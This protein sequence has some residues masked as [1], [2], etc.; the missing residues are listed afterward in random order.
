MIVSFLDHHAA[1]SHSTTH[2]S[3]P[4]AFAK[5]DAAVLHG[6]LFML[7]EVLR[8]VSC[9]LDLFAALIIA[10]T[11]TTGSRVAVATTSKA[12]PTASA[13]RPTVGSSPQSRM[14]FAF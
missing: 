14:L 13:L 4:F 12:S 2:R 8:C 11:A 3:I 6:G 10:S 7:A 1:R 5:L 9:A